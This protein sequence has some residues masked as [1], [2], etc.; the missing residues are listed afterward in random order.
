MN[1]FCLVSAVLT[2]AYG[3]SALRAALARAG[4]RAPSPAGAV[5]SADSLVTGYRH[6]TRVNRTPHAVSSYLALLC[7]SITPEDLKADSANPHLYTFGDDPL[8]REKFVTVYVN[9]T[10]ERAMLYE[11]KPMFPFGSVIVKEK[12]STRTSVSP[13]LLTVMRKREPGYDSAGG[14]WEYIVMDGAG[15]VTRAQGRLQN[16]QSCHAQWKRTDYVSRA[17]LGADVTRSLR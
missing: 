13:E 3:S 5:R 14:D 4:S 12:L 7:R 8:F 10:A 9:K 15:K 17:Y 2:V 1:I 6:W 11:R 16:C